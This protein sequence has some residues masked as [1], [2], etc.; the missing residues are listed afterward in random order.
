MT[1]PDARDVP[2]QPIKIISTKEIGYVCATIICVV[3]LAT[4][5]ITAL[6]VSGTIAGGMAGVEL[7]KR[8]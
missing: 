1:V 7:G 6:I 5:G 8:W 2:I 4:D 3:M